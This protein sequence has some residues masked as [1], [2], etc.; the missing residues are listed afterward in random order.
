MYVERRVTAFLT[1]S[2]LVHLK[3]TRER[4]MQLT[5]GKTAQAERKQNIQ[6]SVGGNFLVYSCKSKRGK[7]VDVGSVRGYMEREV[8][9][10]G[11]MAYRA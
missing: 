2:H 9:G 4:I 6:G 5:W 1:R 8:R 10:R 7:C 11:C 3:E